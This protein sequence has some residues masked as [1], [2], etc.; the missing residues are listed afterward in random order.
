MTCYQG[1]TSAYEAELLRSGGLWSLVGWTIRLAIEVARVSSEPEPTM[2]HRLYNAQ[3][4]V[5][6]C[7]Y[8]GA[9]V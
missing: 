8:S 3:P 4:R 6:A 5:S 1:A 7:A 9:S 2:T